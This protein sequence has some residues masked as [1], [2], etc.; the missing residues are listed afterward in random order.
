MCDNG[1]DTQ[2]DS[3]T[4]PPHQIITQVHCQPDHSRELSYYSLDSAWITLEKK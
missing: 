2:K 3:E 4:L 1:L